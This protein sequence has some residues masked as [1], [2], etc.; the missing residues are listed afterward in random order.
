[1][2]KGIETLIKAVQHDQTK[3]TVYDGRACKNYSEGCAEK[4]RQY[5]KTGV[6]CEHKC[7]Y[8]DKFKW[9]ID[10]AKHY[11]EKTGLSVKEILGGWEEDRDYWFLNYY[12]EYNQ[13][14]IKGTTRVV[15][16]VE[17]FKK[18]VWDKG[19][20]CPVCGGI[21]TDPEECNAGLPMKS[22]KK[23]N[24]KSYGL[25]SS[26]ISVYFKKEKRNIRIF[27]PVAWE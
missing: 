3:S 27:M 2:D 1:M 8:C 14:E 21:S 9:V 7:E 10:R 18:E 22:G 17:A 25:V 6:L 20:R 23:C 19:F 13:P 11:A 16:S 5:E 15:E 12:K 24:W 26:G 4:M